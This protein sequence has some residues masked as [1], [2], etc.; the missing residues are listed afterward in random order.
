MSDKTIIVRVFSDAGRNR[1]EIDPRATCE[2]LM[3]IIG[4]KIGISTHKVKF[5]KDM[6]YRKA[7]K[8]TASSSLKKAGIVNG[9][10]VYVPAKNAKMQDIAPAPKRGGDV[11]MEDEE[12]K[13]D[14]NTKGGGHQEYHEEA[15]MLENGLTPHCQHDTKTKCLHCLGVD[16]HN[17]QAVDYQCNHPKG[18]M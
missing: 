3:E 5:Y 14:T 2:E 13:I 15:K 11:E 12:E 10:M 6:G 9:T 4:S 7:F 17:F 16:K 8:Y 18:Q 1:I